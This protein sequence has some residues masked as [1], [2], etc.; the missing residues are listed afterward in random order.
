MMNAQ[1]MEKCT[2]LMGQSIK[3]SGKMVFSME[4]AR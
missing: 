2:G 4:S 3:A 1:A